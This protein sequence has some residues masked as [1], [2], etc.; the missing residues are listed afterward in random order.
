MKRRE[1]LMATLRG[2]QV[3]RPPVSFYEI[4]GL[5]EVPGNDDPFNIYTHPSWHP[6]IELARE[7]TDRIV[8][9]GVAYGSVTPDPIELIAKTESVV[10]D[11]VRFVTKH[12]QA[13]SRMLT[14]RTRLAPDINTIWT[15]EHLLKDV[16]DLQAFLNI[17]PPQT[18]N[19]EINISGVIQTEAALG[20][21][22]IVMIDTPDPLCL[23]ASLF[24]MAEY[25][26]IA[27]TEPEL[28]H[29]LLEAGN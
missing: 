20:D 28:F 25:T 2:D 18:Q 4:N 6:L 12:V 26:I 13:G 11:G 27:M 10:R 23:S 22:G 29:Q 5:D 17:P 1:R 3:D 8:M 7:K 24:D 19:G 21:T 16:D 15:E 14:T 9:R